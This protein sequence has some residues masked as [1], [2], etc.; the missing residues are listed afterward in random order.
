MSGEEWITVAAVLAGLLLGLP[1]FRRIAARCGAPA[2]VARKSV[3]VAMGVVCVSF[4]WI[5]SR[6]LPVWVLALA[7]TVPLLLLRCIPALRQGVGSALHGIGR[8]SYGEMLFAPAV[9]AVFHRSGM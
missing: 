7:A 2:E 6:P 5:F 4:P 1:L 9:A 3:H 8:I